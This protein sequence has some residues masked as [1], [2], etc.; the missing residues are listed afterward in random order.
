MIKLIRCNCFVRNMVSNKVDNIFLLPHTNSW[1]RN[2]SIYLIANITCN[3]SVLTNTNL[4]FRKS[5]FARWFM[6][7]YSPHYPLQNYE[8]QIYSTFEL[9]YNSTFLY[10]AFQNILS[11]LY[12]SKKNFLC[13]MYFKILIF[14]SYICY[15]ILLI[16][17]YFFQV[18]K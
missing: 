14:C 2:V 8:T 16:V 17:I 15:I 7:S 5:G 1:H 18:K 13:N 10:L 11:E 9:I 3:I 4:A 12:W 6:R